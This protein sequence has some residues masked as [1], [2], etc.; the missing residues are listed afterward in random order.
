MSANMNDMIR[1]QGNRARTIRPAPLPD[2]GQG[3][4]GTAGNPMVMPGANM[5]APAP[6]MPPVMGQLQQ[7]AGQPQQ[8]AAQPVVQQPAPP[9]PIPVQPQTPNPAPFVI[10]PPGAAP[11]TNHYNYQPMAGGAWMVYPPGVSAPESAW[12]VSMPRQPSTA[13]LTRMSGELGRVM[14]QGSPRAPGV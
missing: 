3:S 4:G 7:G 6:P 5:S 8:P 11:D 9:P 2:I 14:R 13:D 1:N 12:Q 10:H